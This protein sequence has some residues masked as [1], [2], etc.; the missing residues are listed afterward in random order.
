VVRAV[1]LCI[2]ALLAA[3]P[4]RSESLAAIAERAK[5]AVVHL[6]VYD[7]SG[8]QAST[9]SGFF[10]SADGR[11]VTNHHVIEDAFR[12]TATLEGGRELE[13]EGLL[14]ADPVRDL[15]ILDFAGDGYPFL[16]LGSIHQVKAGE[17]VAVIGSPIGL[18]GSLST[19]IVS[20]VREQGLDAGRPRE[21]HSARAWQLQITAP[22]SPGSSGS[23]I[24]SQNG[25]VIGVAVGIVDFGQALNFGVSADAAAELL[26][27]ISPDATPE[28]FADLQRGQV[29]DNLLVSALG[30]G[31]AALVGWAIWRFGSRK[32]KKKSIV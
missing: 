6:N 19:G 15:A 28:S 31:T 24:L 14:A 23:P 12:V 32:A 25:V 18:A 3:A 4:A 13:A 29:R 1:L 20:A 17:P 27:G 30:I 7:G 21:T 11:V 10:V 26:A 2:A 9:G 5:S 22:I 8:R 16:R